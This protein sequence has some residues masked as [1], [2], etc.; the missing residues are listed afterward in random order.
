MP[1]PVRMTTLLWLMPGCQAAPTRGPMPHW[2]PVSVV[3][4]TPLVPLALL[5]AMIRPGLVMVSV[6][7]Q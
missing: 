1:A 2:R 4:L 3:L 5:P 7:G 6:P